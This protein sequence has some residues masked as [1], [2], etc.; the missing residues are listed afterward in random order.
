MIKNIRPDMEQLTERWFY[1]VYRFCYLMTGNPRS[2]EE[3]TFQTFLYIGDEKRR[4][5]E[6]RT[7][8][9]EDALQAADVFACA[10]KTCDDF[11]LRGMRRIKSRSK[12]QAETQFPV[13]D[14]LW[15]FLHLP[16]K[17]KEALYL[18]AQTGLSAA[19]IA[20]ILHVP[21]RRI[22][23]YLKRSSALSEEEIKHIMPSASFTETFY[24]DILYRFE[25]RSVSVENH[26]RNIRL[27]IDRNVWILAALV[28]LLFAAA[29]IY[30]GGR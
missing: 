13:S 17:Q 19:L 20:E 11:Y 14:A 9:E 27:F 4:R 15:A 22:D 24:D 30:T 5:P 18:H 28:L 3:T 8:A 1:P 21:E 23:A 16:L 12:M 10:K 2:A 29:V 26:L 6:F 25:V 7:S